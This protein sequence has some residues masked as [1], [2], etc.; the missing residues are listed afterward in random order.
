[1]K[2]AF[3]DFELDVARRELRR[4]VE[5][6]AVEP[7]VFDVLALLIAQ[8]DRVVSKDEIT[9]HVWKGRIVSDAAISSRIKAAR[10]AIGDDGR[11][12]RL[13]KTSHGCGFRFIGAARELR[14][15]A[16]P[17]GAA[18]SSEGPAAEISAAP[19]SAAQRLPTPADRPSIAVLPF[20]LVGIAGPYAAIAEALPQ[21]L[22]TELSRLR[23]LFVIARGSCFRFSGGGADLSEVGATLGA[24]YCLTGCVEIYGARM[25][26]SMELSDTRD[27]GVVWAERFSAPVEDVH[28]IRTQTVANVIATLEIR[29]AAHEAAQAK[30]QT[31]ENLDAWACHHLGLT[32]LF[33]FTRADTAIAADCFSR[34]VAMDRSFAR[35]HAGLSCTHFLNAFLRYSDDREDQI[36]AARRTAEAGF[37]LDPLDPFVN[38]ALGRSLY[39]AGDLEGGAAWLERATA[40]SP[41]YAQAIYAR[42]WISAVSGEGEEA[43]SRVDESMA[44]SP[45]DPLHYAMM[46]TRA[47]SHLVR[48]D[49]GQ[50]AHWAERAARAPGA[51]AL[52]SVIAAIA[53]GLNGD[54]EKARRWGE[55]SRRR[56]PD[57]SRA[58]FFRSFPFTNADDRARIAGAL[59]RAGL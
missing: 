51:H 42:G 44:L 52:I 5:P 35:A 54:E 20:R 12:Q 2:Y 10:R 34:A 27:G 30:L 19:E 49:D 8:R 58:D 56:S 45:L 37:A 26:I 13:I 59:D 55:A 38:F 4:G 40:L 31:S 32:H 21:D 14:R 9:E 33:R 6:I 47:L 43:Q 24:R 3:D 46:A 7:Q 57:L 11:T 18:L 36:S 39:V 22:I 53:H 23:W 16:S 41:S 28:E 1:M 29:I 48:G 50:A 17:E 25:T 15:E